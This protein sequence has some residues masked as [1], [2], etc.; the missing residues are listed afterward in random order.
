MATR[1]ITHVQELHHVSITNV[2]FAPHDTTVLYY[3]TSD[4][5]NRPYRVYQH[6]IGTHCSQDVLLFEELDDAYFVDLN[7]TK[8]GQ[9]VTIN[10]NTKITSEVYMIS[11]KTVQLIRKRKVGTTYFVEHNQGFLYLLVFDG[12]TSKSQI[13]RAPIA[14]PNEWTIFLERNSQV[15]DLVCVLYPTNADNRTC[16]TST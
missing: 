13:M 4:A 16:S 14:N 5:L 9:I 2:D 11:G 15:Q 3:T 12:D 6:K 7:K 8:D 10:V 1:V